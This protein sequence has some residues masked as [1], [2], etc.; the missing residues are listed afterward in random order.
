MIELYTWMTDNGYET[1]HSFERALEMEDQRFGDAR[2]A[3]NPPWYFW[4]YMYFR[5]GLFGEQLSRYLERYDRSR[6]HFT[7][8]RALSENPRETQEGVHRFLG[9]EPHPVEHQAENVTK[10]VRSPRV[11]FHQRQ[12]T[13]LLEARDWPG[14]SRVDRLVGRLNRGTRP[15]IKPET[16]ARLLERFA[17]DIA[18]T[19][20]LCGIDTSNA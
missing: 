7:T 19:E 5:S 1:A 9:V 10:G 16:R 8:L 2:F 17:D 14:A 6:F 12:I 18:L 15:Q 3:K 11:R 13:D 20:A 4:N